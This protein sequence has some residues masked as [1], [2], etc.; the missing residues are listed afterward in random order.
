MIENYELELAREV[1]GFAAAEGA[2]GSRVTLTK[3]VSDIIGTLNGATDKVSHCLD[4]S[5]SLSLF[6]GGRFGTFSTN[7]LD[8]ES[9]KKFVSGAVAMTRVLAEDPLRVLPDPSRCCTDAKTGDELGLY[10]PEY[11]KV[12]AEER[13]KTALEAAAYGREP[14]TDAYRIISEE[15]EYSDSEY[16]MVTLDSQGLFCRHRETSFEYGTEVTIE[17]VDGS[18]YSAFWWES[19]PSRKGLDTSGVGRTAVRR[20]AA[21][22]G[23]EPVR[24]GKYKMVLDREVAY[25]LVTP[26]LS[27]LGGYAL[28]Q[29]NSFLAGTLG[30]STFS[31][32]LTI[33]DDCHI[34]GQSGSRLFD[35]EGVA[36]TVAPVIDKGVVSRYFINTYIAGKM[37][38]APTVEDCARAHVLPWPQPGLDR[39]AIL[40]R[41]GSGILVT[42]FNGGNSNSATGDFSYGIEGFLFEGGRITKPV[43]GMLITG[44]FTELWNSLIAAGDDCRPCQSKL[45]PT[46]AFDN[47]DFSG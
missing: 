8:P 23:A 19:S 30:K 41:C 9:L 1:M 34:K 31:E 25:K 7:Q 28:Q 29:G 32:G 14:D 37:G 13:M 5:L 46:L 16:D 44:N 40:E 38:I 10:D 4:R 21:Q 20:A 47:T 2:R 15:G 27:A 26:L 12:T 33:I 35:S 24:S 45:I 3:S 22:I 17:A 6:A 43:S 39:Q 18:K 36:T 11:R 42:G